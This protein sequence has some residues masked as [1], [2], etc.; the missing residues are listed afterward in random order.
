MSVILLALLQ[1]PAFV[2]TVPQR[3]AELDAA[4][5][6]L[7]TATGKRLA[8]NEPEPDERERW[9]WATTIADECEAEIFA[10]ADSDEAI[11]MVNPEGPNSMSKRQ[12]LR[13]EANYYVDRMIREHFE[14]RS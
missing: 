14:A 9:E 4:N 2:G 6:C 3:N 13:A 7:V 1:A 5:A 12:L 10:A 11:L 8:A